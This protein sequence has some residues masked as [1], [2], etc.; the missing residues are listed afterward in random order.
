MCNSVVFVAAVS[1]RSGRLFCV[2]GLILLV[3][4]A[5]ISIDIF[6][7]ILVIIVFNCPLSCLL[8]NS[9]EATL[10]W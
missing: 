8:V 9:G 2:C 4:P 1:L 3:A 10:L 5:M 6:Y 7:L